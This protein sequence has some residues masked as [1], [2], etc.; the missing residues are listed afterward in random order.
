MM[1]LRS[2]AWF[3]RKDRDGF[4]YRSWMKNQGWPHDVFEGRP[5]IGI[6]NTWS[7][8]TPCNSHFRELAEF[9][10]RGVWEAGGFPL[11]FPVMSLGEVL[12]RP[13]AMLFRNLASMDVE[14]SIRG[15]PLDGVVLLMG[16]DKTTP[17]LLMG[18]ASC[19]LPTIGLSGGPMLSGKFHGRDLGSGTGVWQMSEQVR[20]GEMKL[21]EFFEAESCMHRSKGHCMTMGTA[22]TM[23]SMVEALGMSLPGNAAIPAVDARRHTLAQ[24]TGRRIVEMVNED[25]VMSR[26]LTRQAFENAIRANAT[27]GGS[28]NAVIHLLAIAGRIGVPLGLDDFERLGSGMPCLVNLQPSG[29]YLMEDFFYAG[30]VPAVLREMGEAGALERDALTANGQTIWK[31]VCEAPCWNREVIHR[32]AEPLKQKA[33]IAVLRG[34]L[35]PDGAVIKLSAAS[36][37]LLRH[38]GRAVVFESIDDFH[39]RIDDEALDID[40]SCVMILKNCGPKGYPGMAEVG[41]MPLPPKVLRKGVKDLVR[42]SDARMSGTAYGTVVL[43][44]SPEAAAG[45][46]IALARSGDMVVLDVPGR[47]V[48]LD[49]DDHTLAERRA[50]WKPAPL[51]ER[52]YLRLYVKHVLQANQ[53]ADLDFLAGHSGAPVAR[54]NH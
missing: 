5:V 37:E 51:P 3:G 27:I 7:E 17:S 6:C 47:Q 45:G 40:E 46:P 33:G 43:H 1:K 31:N 2:Q 41:N 14:E 35:A 10:K 54:D 11:E 9:V 23:A 19:D 50:Q 21:E 44:A 15:N 25:L 18:A 52:G 20:S 12:L 39:A 29:S 32:F 24:L 36:P 34:N 8:L 42:I 16:C 26:I 30:G 13:T 4:L 22:S 28:T 49:V 53:G 48:R 38:R